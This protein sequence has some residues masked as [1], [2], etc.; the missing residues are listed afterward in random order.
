MTIALALL[1]NFLLSAP[2][3]TKLGGRC[4]MSGREG[5]QVSGTTPAKPKEPMPRIAREGF[6]P[7]G[8]EP[9]RR[10]S[11]GH[12]LLPK[13]KSHPLR[14]ASVAVVPI[15][16]LALEMIVLHGESIDIGN[17]Q[18]AFAILAT[19]ELINVLAAFASERDDM[20]TGGDHEPNIDTSLDTDNEPSLGRGDGYTDGEGAADMPA[21]VMD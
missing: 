10:L 15:E 3:L 12:M 17:G 1:A 20:E 11:A 5:R 9:R 8:P 21:F 2:L 14:R 6:V 7:A 19:P 13:P 16:R 4:V 18:R